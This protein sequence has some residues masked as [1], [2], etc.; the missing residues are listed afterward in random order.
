MSSGGAS[1]L[2]RDNGLKAE[3]RVAQ[4]QFYQIGHFSALKET[5][6]P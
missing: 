2:K 6:V 4:A 1:F 5:S 3:G